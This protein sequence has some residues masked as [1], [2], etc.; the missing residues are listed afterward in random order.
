VV[1]G[2]FHEL[3]H[4]VGALRVFHVEPDDAACAISDVHATH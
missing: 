3:G 4:P 2:T 1:A